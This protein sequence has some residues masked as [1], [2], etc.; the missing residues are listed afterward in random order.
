MFLNSQW[1]S[2]VLWFLRSW[3][4]DRFKVH[5]WRQKRLECVMKRTAM[6]SYTPR[7]PSV[8]WSLERGETRPSSSTRSQPP[9][10][11]R[12]VS[13]EQK[14]DE[15]T[16]TRSASSPRCAARCGSREALSVIPQRCG[17]TSP[18][19]PLSVSSQRS[20]RKR[21]K[22]R[23]LRCTCT[24]RTKRWRTVFTLHWFIQRRTRRDDV[25]RL[26]PFSVKYQQQIPAG[27]LLVSVLLRGFLILHCCCTDKMMVLSK[28]AVL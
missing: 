7:N 27:L 10:G 1:M 8:P 9:L 28:P 11:V 14:Q 23:A 3:K 21:S 18:V 19:W 24:E 17:N 22:V 12:G 16:V 15:W 4:R 2:Y 26:R 13:E 25:Y 20:V 5:L 6:T